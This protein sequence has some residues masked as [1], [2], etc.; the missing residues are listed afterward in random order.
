[1]SRA[2]TGRFPTERTRRSG[3]HERIVTLHERSYP[4]PVAEAFLTRFDRDIRRSDDV[5]GPFDALW[6]ITVD[7]WVM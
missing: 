2:T 7:R 3:W 5:D 4:E 1:M 6:E